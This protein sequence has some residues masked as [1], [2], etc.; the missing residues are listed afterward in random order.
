MKN[1]K[2][3]Q[4]DFNGNISR[5]KLL[6]GCGITVLA[7]ATYEI[8]SVFSDNRNAEADFCSVGCIDLCVTSCTSN[9]CVGDTVPDPPPP[10]CV[11]GFKGKDGDNATGS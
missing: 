7:T 1:S 4:T 3:H 8:I 5:R 11:Q 2:D 6:K 10:E 9:T